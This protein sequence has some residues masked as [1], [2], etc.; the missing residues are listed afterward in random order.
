MLHHF[1]LR[2]VARL[3]PPARLLATHPWLM[4]SFR[5]RLLIG[6][7]LDIGLRGGQPGGL[8]RPMGVY[9]YI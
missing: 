8:R 9:D 1:A 4:G 2:K 6:L 3:Y 5:I 7:T